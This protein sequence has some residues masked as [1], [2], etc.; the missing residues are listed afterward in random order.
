[1]SR[2]LTTTTPVPKSGSCISSARCGGS[3][4]FL[5]LRLLMWLGQ[6]FTKLAL[7]KM[8]GLK[9]RAGPDAGTAS[10]AADD[11]GSVEDSAPKRTARVRPT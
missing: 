6:D 7:R 5:V 4:C 2:T 9:R 3:S 1:M 8:K 10:D 11:S